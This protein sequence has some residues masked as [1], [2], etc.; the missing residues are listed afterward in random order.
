MVMYLLDDVASIS[1]ERGE[2]RPVSVHDDESESVVV[3][4]KIGQRFSVEL[5]IAKVERSVDRLERLEIDCDFLFFSFVCHDRA[6]VDDQTVCRNYIIIL[7][8]IRKKS[9]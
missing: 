8:Q 7:F 4:Q 3:G 1:S 5:V 6:A 2:E 9:I